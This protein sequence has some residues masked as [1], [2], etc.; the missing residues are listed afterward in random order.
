MKSHNI[1][2]NMTSTV[3][4]EPV[5]TGTGKNSPKQPVDTPAT[6]P[7]EQL[8]TALYWP[9]VAPSAKA[10]QGA[11]LLDTI[12]ATVSEYVVI[13]KHYADLAA[14]WCVM[15]WLHPQLEVAAFLNLTGPAKRV[16]KS[17]LL[18]IMATLVEKP[19]VNSGPITE[20]VL[21]RVVTE[22]A[23]TLLLDEVDTYLDDNPALKGML[24]GAQQRALAVRYINVKV[25]EDWV[26]TKFVMWTPILLSGIGP[27]PDTIRDRSI[28]LRLNR[29]KPNERKP[30][31]R[32]ANAAKITKIR[33]GLKRW[34]DD[35]A[36]AILAQIPKLQ[37]PKELHDRA[38][39]GFESLLAIADC[40]GKDWPDRARKAAVATTTHTMALGVPVGERIITDVHR[41]FLDAK[42]ADRISGAT[43]VSELAKIDDSPWAEY[44]KSSAPITTNGLARLLRPYDVR[45][46][47]YRS[48]HAQQ[49]LCRGY[50]LADLEPVFERYSTAA[51]CGG[52]A[53]ESSGCETSTATEKP[54][55]NNVVAVVPLA[56]RGTG[57]DHE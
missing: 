2:P 52:C 14:L 20:S 35:N 7:A 30:K 53:A 1:E 37:F 28:E 46:V 17:T 51:D 15:T 26:P 43:V 29:A 23:P 44:G 41:V 10:Q 31:W 47:K 57:G 11:K 25:G 3:Q 32:E 5:H 42:L 8:G 6:K 56:P 12:S 22:S 34:M 9:E 24:N 39:D 18:K 49:G 36:G 13:D 40:T 27:L 19:L 45:P 55:E 50:T 16:G 54:N 33:L 21:T 48:S 4:D 38:R